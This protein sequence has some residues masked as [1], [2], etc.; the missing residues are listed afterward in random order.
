ML[1]FIMMTDGRFMYAGAA[2]ADASEY[3]PCIHLWNYALGSSSFHHKTTTDRNH[4]EH[5]LCHD[6]RL[7]EEICRFEN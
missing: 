5:E 4:D 6:D 2:H 1:Q 3:R 7:I